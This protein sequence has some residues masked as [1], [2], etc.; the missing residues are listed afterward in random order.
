MFRK[1][2][3]LAVLVLVCTPLFAQSVDTAW[4][5]R[6]TGPGGGGV[7]CDIFVDD[8]GY[9]YVT[10]WTNGIGTAT[11]YTSI[12]YYPS[13]DT[14]WVRRYN[15]LG[16]VRDDPAGLSVDRFGNVYV[17]GES[18]GNGT[19]GDYLTIKYNAS[20]DSLWTSRYNGT[21]NDRDVAEDITVDDSGYIYVT[22]ESYGGYTSS[23]DYVTIK[24]YSNGAICWLQRYNYH[25]YEQALAIAVD[26]SGNVYVT[27]YSGGSSSYMDYATI[28]YKSNGDTAWVRR[29]NGPGNNYD[30]AF[31]LAVDDSGNVY[32]TGESFAGLGT[33]SDYA[34][35]KYKPNGDTAWL[36][37]YNG[38]ASVEDAAMA[39]TVDHS[40]NVYV[41]G[42]GGGI[43]T[44]GDYTTIKYYPNGDTAWVRSYG[45]PGNYNDIALAIAGDDSGNVYVTGY[46][47]DSLTS[48]D[49]TTIKYDC[50][51][52]Q[53]WLRKY[54]GSNGYNDFAYAIA[55]DKSKNV[56]VTGGSLSD[57]ATI[58]YI[59]FL[60]GDVNVDGKRTVSDAVYLINYL[61][62]GGPSPNPLLSGD[63]NC[64]GKVTIA[65]VVYLINYLFKGGPP[66]AC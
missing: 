54:D 40:G 60:R 45:G 41:T 38:P 50:N 47:Y 31:A 56:Y 66:P 18:G 1:L 7:A 28:K 35:I 33:Y 11:D 65:D 62:K 6:Y 8:A 64:D 59:Q 14:A 10:G 2:I 24:Y 4:V 25:D 46:G 16:N 29:Y 49:Y 9:V 52:N 20:G 15:G 13:G 23:W 36:R 58:K 34:T 37:R 27:G 12:K 57:Y 5:R 55:L 44:Y 22:G 63:L 32:V 30:W 3:I 61:F 39:I 26:R 48:N 19:G 17:T 42:Q 51:G 21:G 43:G 53:I